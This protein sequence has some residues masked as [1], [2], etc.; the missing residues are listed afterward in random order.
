MASPFPFV[1]PPL[2]YAAYIFDCDGTLA[3]SMP[4]HM[5]AWNAGLTA[6]D[7]PFRV[8]PSNFMSVAG[9]ALKQTIEYWN[10]VH[11][12]QIDAATVMAA[13]EPYYQ[14]HR[15]EMEAIDP[16]VDFARELHAAGKPLAVA[17]GGS[18]ADVLWTLEHLRINH[19]FHAVLTA[20]D[21]PRAKPAPDLFLAAAA[22]LGV[23]PA[24][25]LA[26]DDSP[27]GVEAA[28]AAGMTV[29]KLPSSL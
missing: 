19:L 22:V 12:T 23:A 13:K 28:E 17:S 11:V 27:L 1:P 4:L 8:D 6:A 10:Q 9:M 16:V 20:D 14:S 18:R 5:R 21:V 3:H 25:C 26:L 7:A 29:V 15:Q 24:H 2:S